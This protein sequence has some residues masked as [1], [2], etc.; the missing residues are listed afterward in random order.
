MQEEELKLAC[1]KHLAMDYEIQDQTLSWAMIG[2]WVSLG[3]TEKEPVL[4]TPFLH[5]QF[6]QMIR[7]EKK[8]REEPI[9]EAFTQLGWKTGNCL[10]SSALQRLEPQDKLTN[11]P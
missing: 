3:L 2:A 9:H 4:M 6:L 1:V 5:M 7:L 10:S 11:C 8:K